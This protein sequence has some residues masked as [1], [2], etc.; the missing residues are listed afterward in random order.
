MFTAALCLLS[1]PVV[2]LKA[3][4]ISEKSPSF[5]Q[6]RDEPAEPSKNVN[7]AAQATRLKS[8]ENFQDLIHKARN[9]TLQQDRLQASQVLLRG[10]SRESRGSTAYRE[11]LRTLENLS[12]VFYTEKAQ[13]LFAA[14]EAIVDSRP[15]EA[16]EAYLEAYKVEERNVSILT[17]LARAYLK[18]D[19]CDRADARVKSAE[20]INPYASDVRLLRLQVLGCQKNFELL[21]GKLNQKD[22]DLESNERFVRSIQI[23]EA[24]SRKD[25]K[26][27]KMILTQWE[28]S[29]GDYPEVYFWKWKVS[30]DGE[31][32]DRSAANKYVQ[33]CQALT[34]RKKRTFAP[35]VDLCKGKEA[36]EAFLRETETQ[37]QGIQ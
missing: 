31:T 37:P 12:T 29:A 17:G 23:Q 1:V 5:S 27:V 34:P 9:L 24:L 11:L 22:L 10:L 13:S 26:K 14:A 30:R 20:E 33:L 35:D 7:R 2:A 15:K 21:A 36:V 8:E 25:F 32:Q 3:E 16:L 4:V 6:G 18:T 19:D 28:T